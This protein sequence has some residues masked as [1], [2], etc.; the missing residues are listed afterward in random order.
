MT[1]IAYKDGVL[2]GDSLWCGEHGDVYTLANKVFRFP[3]GV[4]YGGAGEGD[5]REFVRILKRARR[6]EQLPQIKG[7]RKLKQGL[8]A[9]MVFPDGRV[10][11][12]DTSVR[13]DEPVGI[14]EVMER[15]A[16]IGA[17]GQWALAAMDNGRSA[18]E[19]VE[20]TC[21]RNVYCRLP[22]TH[23]ELK[24]PKKPKR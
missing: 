15:V 9:I 17:G 22:V 11:T 18:I 8:S 1:V 19:A 3:S 2:A 10:F 5:D 13:D 24:P 20:Y 16:A 12:V 7:L 14:S 23:V 6:P 4:L 21:K